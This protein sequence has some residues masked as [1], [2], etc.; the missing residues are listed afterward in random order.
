M[1]N[2][3]KQE[4]RKRNKFV[5]VYVGGYR[6]GRGYVTGLTGVIR[7]AGLKHCVG[8]ANIRPSPTGNVKAPKWQ[9]PII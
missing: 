5:D 6:S 3:S 7:G 1:N 4:N 8:V 9:S 2:Q